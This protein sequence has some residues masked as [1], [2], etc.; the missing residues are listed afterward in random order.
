MINRFNFEVFGSFD[1]IYRTIGEPRRLLPDDRLPE[2]CERQF[3][4]N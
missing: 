1:A 4:G 2:D 3:E